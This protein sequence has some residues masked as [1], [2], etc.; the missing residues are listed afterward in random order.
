[1]KSKFVHTSVNCMQQ[2]AQWQQQLRTLHFFAPERIAYHVHRFFN[3]FKSQNPTTTSFAEL[4]DYLHIKYAFS[5]SKILA[6]FAFHYITTI[7]SFA[8]RIQLQ[9]QPFRSITL[10]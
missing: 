6:L 1:M 9:P 8:T 2:A 3:L 7:R 10:S 4:F 5:Y